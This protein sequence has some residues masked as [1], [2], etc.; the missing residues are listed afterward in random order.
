MS[1]LRLFWVAASTVI[2]FSSTQ[3][4]GGDDRTTISVGLDQIT[5][6]GDQAKGSGTGF[7]FRT[8]SRNGA[9]GTFD[10]G[11][12]VEM[13]SARVENGKSDCCYAQDEIIDVSTFGINAQVLWSVGPAGL[14]FEIGVHQ[15]D[16]VQNLDGDDITGNY[17]TTKIA[18]VATAR[19]GERW[20]VDALYDY[21]LPI[22]EESGGKTQALQISGATLTLGYTL[23]K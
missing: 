13:K 15:I 10:G 7:A 17:G 8:M 1:H 5:L 4:F 19:I 18:A 21:F 16:L 2:A 22:K 6:S 12:G 11:F 3:A 14:G 9:N 23:G 20:V